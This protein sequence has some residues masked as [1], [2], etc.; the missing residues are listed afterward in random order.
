MIKGE[1][2]RDVD[3]GET[4]VSKKLGQTR[5]PNVSSSF[6]IVELGRILERRKRRAPFHAGH[7]GRRAY[8]C[9]AARRF[10]EW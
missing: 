10:G 5:P 8:F 4:E 2:E 7:T 6:E 1:G 3:E 9:M